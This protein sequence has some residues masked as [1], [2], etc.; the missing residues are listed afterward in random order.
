MLKTGWRMVDAEEAVTVR[1]A[2]GRR[3]AWLGTGRVAPGCSRIGIG[4]GCIPSRGEGDSATGELGISRG[5]IRRTGDTDGDSKRSALASLLPLPSL[6]CLPIPV[7]LRGGPKL[8]GRARGLEGRGDAWL[9]IWLGRRT[10]GDAFSGDNDPILTGVPVAGVPGADD[11][12]GELVGVDALWPT[13]EFWRRNG[14]CRTLPVSE[15]PGERVDAR[16]VDC[17]FVSKGRR[18]LMGGAYT[19]HAS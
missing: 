1:C 18:I 3:P 2:V 9:L 7:L 12:V 13:C 10:K 15:P 17:V 6:A 4:G 19:H 11:F 8:G 5:E 14:D 16:N